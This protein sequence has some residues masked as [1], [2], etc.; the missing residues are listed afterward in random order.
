MALCA[1]KAT[2]ASAL[3]TAT[4]GYVG[5]PKGDGTPRGRDSAEHRT[6][7]MG[8]DIA[9]AEHRTQTEKK[10]GVKGVKSCKVAKLRNR[11]CL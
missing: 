6:E 7:M 4:C 5:D 11:I 10:N 9:D 1:I 8:L 2:P 3:P